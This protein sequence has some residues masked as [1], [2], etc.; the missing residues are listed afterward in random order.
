MDPSFFGRCRQFLNDEVETY[1]EA[2]A[3][4]SAAYDFYRF[5][6]CVVGVATSAAG[7]EVRLTQV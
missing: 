2:I 4:L 7:C 1:S 6:M 3:G 5:Y